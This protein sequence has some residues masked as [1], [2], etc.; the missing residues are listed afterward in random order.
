MVQRFRF[1]VPLFLLVLLLASGCGDASSGSAATTSVST[2]RLEP[3]DVRVA[4]R[5]L[6]F[7]SMVERIQGPKGNI[8]SF[9][10]RAHGPHDTTLEFSIGIG[11]PPKPVRVPGAGTRGVVWEESAGFVF[12]DD[13]AVARKFTT[14]AQW[15]QVAV[16][17][18]EVYGAMCR[19]ATGKPCPV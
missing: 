10:G 17:A 11:D 19:A 14:A 1:L 9:R 7:S 18:A 15:H 2:G 4:L 13:S 16:M 8:A 3:A 5:T 12:N 6:P